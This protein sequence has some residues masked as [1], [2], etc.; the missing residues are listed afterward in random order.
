LKP[1]NKTGGEKTEQ[2]EDTAMRNWDQQY[3]D[4][5]Q[6]RN[7]IYTG[8]QQSPNFI[9]NPVSADHTKE[10]SSTTKKCQLF[11]DKNRLSIRC[12]SACFYYE[13]N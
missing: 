3:K 10:H 8:K 13:N 12:L 4:L 6:V 1:R 9:F 7:G 5:M 2:P 11:I